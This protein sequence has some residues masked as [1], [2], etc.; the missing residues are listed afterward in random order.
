MLITVE[1]G[2]IGGF[3]LSRDADAGRARHARRRLEDARDG[4]CRTSSSIT[5]R[6]TRCTPA[7]A[8]TRKSIDHAKVFEALG[9]DVR[10]EM[11]EAGLTWCDGAAIAAPARRFDQFLTS[12]CRQSRTP[13]VR[14]M[15]I[16]LAG[17]DVDLSDGAGVRAQKGR[18]VQE[19]YGLTGLYPARQPD[20]QTTP[21]TS[22]CAIFRANEA[23]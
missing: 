17:P 7:Q 19:K 20:R 21:A 4:A 6:R 13:N 23:R 14:P 1:E 8:S 2:S 3:W 22:R 18:A 9:K 16:Y 11:H 10:T 12:I 15:K 5:T